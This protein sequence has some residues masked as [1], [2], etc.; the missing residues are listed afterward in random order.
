MRILV[1][2]VGL[3]TVLVL[4]LPVQSTHKDSVQTAAAQHFALSAGDR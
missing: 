4:L 2:V 1:V 3:L